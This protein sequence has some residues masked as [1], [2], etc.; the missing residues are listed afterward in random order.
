MILEKPRRSSCGNPSESAET[1]CVEKPAAPVTVC[2]GCEQQGMSQQWRI[3][4][5]DKSV[6]VDHSRDGKL[7]QPLNCGTQQI[8]FV[9]YSSVCRSNPLNL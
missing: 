3:F 8:S 5:E 4:S 6:Q 9:N 1:A 2:Y 7:L